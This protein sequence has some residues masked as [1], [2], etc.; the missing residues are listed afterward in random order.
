MSELR[1]L[2]DGAGKNPTL[3]IKGYQTSSGDVIDYRVKV[4][5][6]VGYR[7]LVQDAITELITGKVPVMP[8]DSWNQAVQEQQA[9]WSRTLTSEQPEEPEGCYSLKEDGTFVLK[10]LEVLSLE[11]QHTAEKKPVNS[12]EKTKMKKW[13]VDHT[14]MKRFLGQ[15]NLCPGKYQTV[16]V[17]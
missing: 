10:N 13:I 9:S 12:A 5:G 15:L 1:T 14:S 4:V 8:G 17:L 6:H 7:K 3:E 16:T 2:L 11:M